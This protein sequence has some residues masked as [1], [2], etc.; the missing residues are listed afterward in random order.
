ML[1]GQILGPGARLASQLTSTGAGVA[2]Q[3]KELAGKEESK[4]EGPLAALAAPAAESP[5]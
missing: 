5:H 3:I 1:V 4:D 2:G